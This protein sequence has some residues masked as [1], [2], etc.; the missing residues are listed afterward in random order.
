M[1]GAPRIEA[2]VLSVLTG[3]VSPIPSRPGSLSAID[4]R[5][6]AGPARCGLLGFEGDE[7]ADPRAHGGPVKAV[8]VYPVGQWIL[9]AFSDSC[10]LVLT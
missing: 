6:V 3:R 9:R 4:K 1:S 5:P 8:R 7:Q 10:W 2:T